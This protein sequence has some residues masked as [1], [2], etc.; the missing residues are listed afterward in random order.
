MAA[1]SSVTYL[2]RSAITSW[3][4]LQSVPSAANTQLG[5]G[6]TWQD[7][8]AS[9]ALGTTYTNTTSKPIFVG[10]RQTSTGAGGFNGPATVAGVSMAYPYNYA[11][12]SGYYC[13]TNFIVPPGATY[14]CAASSSTLGQW[15]ELR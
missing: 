15:I 6:Q 8:T 2:Y 3:F 13:V 11:V 5:V 12:G 10:I 14:S 1:G 4:P 9:R 7:V